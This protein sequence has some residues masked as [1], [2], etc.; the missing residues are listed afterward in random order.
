MQE[1]SAERAIVQ[2]DWIQ[3]QLLDICRGKTASRAT[4]DAKGGVEKVYDRQGALVAL[5][6]TAG[7][8][9]DVNVIATASAAA[10][11]EIDVKDMSNAERSRRISWIIEEAAAETGGDAINVTPSPAPPASSTCRAPNAQ[12]PIA[13]LP[14]PTERARAM[15]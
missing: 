3:H 13:A 15:A 14:S 9:A 10:S 4:G 11:A 5:G 6:K 12:Q 7:V 1:Q 2:V 8:G